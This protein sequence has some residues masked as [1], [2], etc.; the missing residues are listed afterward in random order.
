MHNLIKHY[1]VNK[2]PFIVLEDLLHKKAYVFDCD[3]K[4]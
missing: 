2:Y 4:G 3:N 1:A